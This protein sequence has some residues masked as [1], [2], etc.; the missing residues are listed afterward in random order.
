M[1]SEKIL[2][3]YQKQIIKEVDNLIKSGEKSFFIKS[4][5][6]TG[7]TVCLNEICKRFSKGKNLFIGPKESRKAVERDFTVEYEFITYDKLYSIYKQKQ[8]NLNNDFDEYLSD[9][10]V[11]IMDEAHLTGAKLLSKPLHDIKNNGS[12]DLFIGASAHSRRTDQ[13]HTEEDQADVLFDS[14]IVGDFNLDYCFDNNILTMPEYYYCEANLNKEIE[15]EIRKIQ[16]SKIPLYIKKNLIDN[17]QTVKLTYENYSSLEKTL[18]RGL[19]NYKERENLKIIIFINRINKKDE[20]LKLFDPILKEIFN[21]KDINYYSFF[22][23]CKDSILTDFIKAK[24]INILVAVDKLNLSLHHEDLNVC[25]MYRKTTSAIVYEQQCGRVLFKDKAGCI[26][27]IVDNGHTVN[28]LDYSGSK[29]ESEYVIKRSR[30]NNRFSDIVC[31]E[32]EINYIKF[33]EIINLI[34]TKN[35]KNLSVDYKG[36]NNTIKYFT[37]KYR[38]VSSDVFFFMSKDIPFNRALEAARTEY[39]AT[40][41]GKEYSASSLANRFKLDAD[42]IRYEI[43]NNTFKP[44][45]DMIEFFNIETKEESF[46]NIS[47]KVKELKDLLIQRDND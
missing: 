20:V 4:A 5:M 41:E 35:Y 11:I 24:G 29:S 19:K 8:S 40:I 47:L 1:S 44:N 21:N 32:F 42:E 10:S 25:I 34:K 16:F 23:G 43:K 17:L 45:E 31:N 12:Y 27:D 22:S 7:K 26:I 38:V 18:K 37:N 33:K 6:G 9:Y 15:N 39:Y 36:E 30:G 46:E 2:R 28:S 13:R 14:N 3:D